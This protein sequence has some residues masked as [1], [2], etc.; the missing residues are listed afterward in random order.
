MPL[1]ITLIL[2]L[3]LCINQVIGQQHYESS[4]LHFEERIYHANIDSADLIKLEK[5]N[6]M[7]K[8]DSFEGQIYNEIRRVNYSLLPDSMRINAFWNASLIAYLHQDFDLSYNFW[9]KYNTISKDTS[10]QS[11]LL[12]YLVSDS[13]DNVVN[14]LLYDEVNVRD[15][16]IVL[17][18]KEQHRSVKMK[19]SMFKKV[20][21][22]ILPGSGLIIN[23][24]IGKGLLSMGINTG[25][26]LFVR[27]L[28]TNNAW[29]NSF[30]WGSNLIGK[31]YLGGYRLTAKEIE[32]KQLRKKRMRTETS[33]HILD[34]I[35]NKY[36]L[37]FRLFD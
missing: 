22:F 8:A 35:M 30:L 37:N 27:F 4:L 21:A 1:R 20:C 29:V 25:T 3:L 13:R 31:F 33:A 34:T 16:Q 14:R 32:K 24:N 28:I 6:F 2:I 19:G 7:L 9:S 12:G 36:P 17:F 5:I 15:T 11:L 10:S 26:V 23:G 18:D